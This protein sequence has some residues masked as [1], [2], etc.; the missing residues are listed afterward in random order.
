M[1]LVKL[2]PSVIQTHVPSLAAANQ[3]PTH[4]GYAMRPFLPSQELW[5]S[6]FRVSNRSCVWIVDMRINLECNH[7]NGTRMFRIPFHLPQGLI[8]LHLIKDP[9][10]L[11]L[12]KSRLKWQSAWENGEATR[13]LFC[14]AYCLPFQCSARNHSSCVV[15]ECRNHYYIS[16]PPS[17]SLTLPLQRFVFLLQF[18]FLV[19]FNLFLWTSSICTA[20]HVTS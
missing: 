17:I 11:L 16:L 1:Q 10:C 5:T 20:V 6:S 3:P 9:I 13:N 2:K 4:I 15:L 7:S 8:R 18:S 14:I 19:T 12:S